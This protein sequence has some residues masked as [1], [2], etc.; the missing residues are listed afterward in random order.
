M[1]SVTKETITDAFMAVCGANTDPR[2]RF[3]LER[4]SHHI[5]AFAGEVRLTHSEWRKAI[6]ILVEACRISDR[7]RNEVVLLSDLLGLSSM[8][9]MI[10][11]SEGGTPSSVLGPFHMRGAPP[12]AH[13]GDLQQS[14]AGA[15]VF[16]SGT[17][18][19]IDGRPLP[20]ALIELWQTAE[21][22]LY[23]NQDPEQGEFSL[24]AR[25]ASDALGRYALTTVRPAPYT[26][27]T[28]GPAG[29]LLA[30][31]HRHPWRPSHF[32][33]VIEVEGHR[34]LVT[35]LFPDDDPYL[36]EDAVFAVREALILRYHRHDDPAAAPEGFARS[37]SPGSPFYTVTFDFVLVPT[38][39]LNSGTALA[40]SA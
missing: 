20:G 11:S 22:G 32:H 28:D 14:N 38:A 1:R 34:T 39:T 4:L 21:N 6:D 16:L 37:S 29:E 9:D 15:T 8:V 25:L 33:F 27:P 23:S 24:R 35:E 7:H 13:G 31:M 30:A 26:V 18:R 2:T 19:S 5:H 3:L 40:A 12:L 17:I 10:N 36:D